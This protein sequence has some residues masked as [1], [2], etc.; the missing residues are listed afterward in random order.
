MTASQRSRT[1]VSRRTLRPDGWPGRA[2]GPPWL[3][4]IRSRRALNRGRLSRRQAGDLGQMCHSPCAAARGAAHVRDHADRA[5]HRRRPPGQGLQH[6]PRGRRHF[7]CA[8]ARLD[9]RAPRRQ[10][11]RQDHHH[12]HDPGPGHA[13]LGDRPGARRRDAA[14]ALPGAA[15]DEFR[16][17][18]YR[19]AAPAHGAAEPHRVRPALRG[20]GPRRPHRR[21]SPSNSTSPSF[22]TGRP[23][24]SRPG[25]RPAWR[26][27]RR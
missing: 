13:D 15:P 1:S 23:A 19:H 10:R 11:R 17:P 3:K 6:D 22:S 16:K 8:R 24:S 7:V 25:R 14:P 4:S 26:S 21:P 27:P 18:L 2:L 5:R 12:R 9:H 20:R